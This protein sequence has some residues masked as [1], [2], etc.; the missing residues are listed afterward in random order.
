LGM[1]IWNEIQQVISFKVGSFSLGNI[2]EGIVVYF[3][4]ATV[5]RFIMQPVAKVVEKI[6]K[7]E[8]LAHFLTT[9]VRVVLNFVAVIIV[10][11]SLGIPIASLLAVFS[12]FGIAIALSVQG[13]LGNLTSG[14][15]LIITQPIKVGEYVFVEG[16]EGIVKEVGLLCTVL[17]T[18]DNRVI[19]VPNSEMNTKKITNFSREPLRRIDLIVGASYDD[20]I[21][22][23]KSALNEA[24][25]AV[26]VLLKDPEPF[27]SV[28][29]YQPHDIQYVVK[30]WV[31]SADYWT[32]YYAL[33][34]AIKRSYEKN[35]ISMSYPHL[36]LH[37]MKE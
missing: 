37:M 9:V 21:D 4:C 10:A 14:I 28:N 8:T 26:P 22:A 36:N 33:L 18:P 12:M 5:I 17:T 25:D 20:G 31:N 29:S 16:V 15:M 24:I 32:G 13:A 1:A 3:I 7:N 34:E 6:C 27:V 2:I 19:Y 35:N 11:D 30:A 23:V